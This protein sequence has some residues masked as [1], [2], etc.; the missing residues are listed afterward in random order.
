MGIDLYDQI[1][2]IEN[3]E[4]Q[5]FKSNTEDTAFEL[6]PV[7]QLLND[8]SGNYG[9][10]FVVAILRKLEIDESFVLQWRLENKF[11]QYQILNYYA[12]NC[13]PSTLPFSNFLNEKNGI[14]KIKELFSQG[15]FLKATLGDASYINQSWDKTGE[16]EQ[17]A[18]LPSLNTGQYK[19]YML[20]KKICIKTEFRV[21]TFSKNII[22]GLSYISHGEN[23]VH[24]HQDLEDFL[25]KILKNYLILF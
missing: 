2:E 21:H 3:A 24:Y 25:N 8:L 22:P 23:Q 19:N 14:K 15:Y 7:G 1:K 11:Q 17:I 6:R 10:L 4:P 18:M 20:Q 12:P 16:F 5:T 13:M 9:A